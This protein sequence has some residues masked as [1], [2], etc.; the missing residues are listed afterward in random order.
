M[1]AAYVLAR[2]AASLTAVQTQQ[3]TAEGGCRLR[4]VR[5]SS[6]VVAHAGRDKSAR[7]TVEPVNGDISNLIATIVG[8]EGTPYEGG[9][10]KVSIQ[11]P[12][13]YRASRAHE[14]ADLAAFV[15]LK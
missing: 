12:P 15:P 9:V 3:A 14:A 13:S 6:A 5:E 11:V 1:A 7:I 10:F 4:E 8:P 2:M